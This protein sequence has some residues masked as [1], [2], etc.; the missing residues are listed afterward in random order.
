MRLLICAVFIAGSL[1]LGETGCGGPYGAATKSDASP[2]ADQPT[3]PE[4]PVVPESDKVC[5]DAVDYM[6]TECGMSEAAVGYD[7]V[8]DAYTRCQA[9]CISGA[10]CVVFG[11]ATVYD[12][13]LTLEQA[14]LA[15]A[16]YNG[17]LSSCGG[18]SSQAGDENDDEYCYIYPTAP[19]CDDDWLPY[20]QR[21]P[22]DPYCLDPDYFVYFTDDP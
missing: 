17:C 9:D 1:V 14:L 4:T 22:S 16:I 19:E 18:G 15:L 11:G 6:M 10:N 3:E 7:G 5:L 21:Y 12:H 8:C 2:V 20:C 13:S